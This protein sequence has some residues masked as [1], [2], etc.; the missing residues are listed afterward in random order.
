MENS[1][2]FSHP[3]ETKIQPNRQ[4]SLNRQLEKLDK[5]RPD[6]RVLANVLT[7]IYQN[8]Q[9][10]DQQASQAQNIRYQPKCAE[11]N[12]TTETIFGSYQ[13]SYEYKPVVD[14]ITD[15][16]DPYGIFSKIESTIK[17]S[18]DLGTSK[19]IEKTAEV[20]TKNT[21]VPV[22]I[23]PF[24]DHD[25]LCGTLEN[26]NIYCHQNSLAADTL[27]IHSHQYDSQDT[28]L[29]NPKGDL[30]LINKL[31]S[32]NPATIRTGLHE[33]GHIV[34]DKYI[35]NNDQERTDVIS[36]LYGIKAGL[37]MAETDP[38]KAADMIFGQVIL[39]NW[40]LTGTTAP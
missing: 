34:E 20:I 14:A 2:E 1:G 36:S 17:N 10:L 3:I 12:T 24:E 28:N 37:L 38:K 23:E 22:I 9:D 21:D 31:L 6:H 8:Y 5:N 30:I 29:K 13:G 16:P 39:Y 32:D 19:I 11:K 7:D 4:E 18:Q 15:I 35:L 40:I 25:D 27:G 26:G 33:L